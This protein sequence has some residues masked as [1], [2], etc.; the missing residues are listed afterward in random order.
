MY[1]TYTIFIGLNVSTFDAPILLR[2]VGEQVCFKTTQSLDVWIADSILL[3][4]YLT[5]AKYPLLKNE[6]GSTNA[7]NAS[8]L[9]KDMIGKIAGSG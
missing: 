4:K 9:T 6:D 8:I 2:H 5:K 7:Y 3:F 1:C